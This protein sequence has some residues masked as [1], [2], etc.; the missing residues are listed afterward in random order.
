[1]FSDLRLGLKPYSPPCSNPEN[2]SKD[3]FHPTA[4]G[5]EPVS[6]APSMVKKI[7][8]AKANIQKHLDLDVTPLTDGGSQ[9]G[10][11][12]LGTGGSLPN[13]YR[14]GECLRPNAILLIWIG[15]VSSTLIT[16]PKWGKILLDSGEGTWGQIS[17]IFGSN[18]DYGALQALRDLKCVFISHVHGDH[19]IGL[20]HLLAK[21]KSVSCIKPTLWRFSC[22]W[23]VLALP[24]SGSPIIHCVDTSSASNPSRIV[25]CAGPRAV[26][27]LWKWSYFCNQ[28]DTSWS[29]YRVISFWD[30]GSRRKWILGG[31][32]N[33][34]RCDTI[35]VS[36][37]TPYSSVEN[38]NK[39]CEILGLDYF[40]T[41]EVHHRCR[42]YGCSFKHK[43]GWSI[44]SAFFAPYRKYYTDAHLRFS[45]DTMP[46]N[47]LV[48]IGMNS[49]VLIHEAT[50]GD[51]EV[52]L[53]LKKAH[54]TIRQAIDIGQKSRP[55]LHYFKPLTDHNS[56][57]ECK[58]HYFNPLLCQA[59]Q[60]ASFGNNGNAW[61]WTRRKTARRSCIRSSQF[62][63][64][65]YVEDALLYSD[66]VSQ[67]QGN[68]FSRD[69]WGS[70][71]GGMTDRGF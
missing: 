52:D 64:R 36:P 14:N 44:T 39:M 47:N 45:G 57:D 7:R 34:S 69:R 25:G 21:R 18:A 13:K 42:A 40:R 3:E 24:T 71:G 61:S 46:T 28:W 43:D 54:S 55:C 63:H 17:R 12:P 10:I 37:S 2:S 70:P 16:I 32:P 27:S 49:T 60:T 35:S 53:A 66:F 9:V 11:I 48:R 58:E 20:A 50:M 5:T 59:S 31:F 4:S 41:V 38:G 1:M 6:L 26:R 65:R 8:A 22:W 68:G 56:Q 62:D 33:V 15:Q 67:F 19:H 51:D 23:I 29:S 30:V